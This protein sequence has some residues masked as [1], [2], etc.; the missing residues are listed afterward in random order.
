MLTLISAL[1]LVLSSFGSA[2]AQSCGDADNPCVLGERSYHMLLPDGPTD[3]S[4]V[5]LLHGG[6]G[7][8]KGLLKSGLAAQAL[9]RGYA[10]IA[11]NGEHPGMRWPK[12]WSVK[13]DGMQHPRDDIEFLHSVM[14]DA[15][16]RH[17]VNGER[18]LLAGFSRG[19]SMVWDMACYAPDFATAYAPIA[20]AFWDA[21][22]ESCTAPV[23]LFHTHGWDDR[24]VPLEG[25]SFGQVV[26]GDVWASLF[27]LRATNGCTNR[28]PESSEIRDSFWFRYWSDCEAGRID[29]LLHPGGHSI[30]KGWSTMAL[31]WFEAR[32]AE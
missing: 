30:P 29:L 26:Q 2:L 13:A 8:G 12:D 11:P 4:T 9:E 32:L 23:D 24:T 20:G 31:D 18:I 16:E 27:V 10:F 19:G 15:V 6:G 28:Q 22:P 3:A 17:G 1:L 14:A 5:I 7:T 21:L 25:R